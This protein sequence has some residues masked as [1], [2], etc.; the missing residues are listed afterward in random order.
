[1]PCKERVEAHSQRWGGEACRAKSVSLTAPT[2]P[3]GAQLSVLL[4][5]NAGVSSFV[6]FTLL[7]KVP[8]TPTRTSS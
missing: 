6:M 1:L 4:V 2:H 3:R 5:L 7:T 8:R